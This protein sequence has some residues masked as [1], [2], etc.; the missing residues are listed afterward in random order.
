MTAIATSTTRASTSAHGARPRTNAQASGDAQSPSPPVQQMAQM[1]LSSFPPG[2]YQYVGVL[3]SLLMGKAMARVRE[4]GVLTPGVGAA[5]S[6]NLSCA[7]CLFADTTT[8]LASDPTSPATRVIVYLHGNM[9]PYLP[10]CR[11]RFAIDI[12]DDDFLL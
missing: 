11:L 4:R 1:S 9:P 10:A 2:T 5:V 8:S 6:R 12:E 3:F 7:S